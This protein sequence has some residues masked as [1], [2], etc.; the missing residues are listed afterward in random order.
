MILSTA[1]ALILQFCLLTDMDIAAGCPVSLKQARRTCGARKRHL[2]R[3]D[4]T[5]EKGGAHRRHIDVDVGGGGS[6]GGGVQRCILGAHSCLTDTAIH[7]PVYQ[8]PSGSAASVLQLS[9]M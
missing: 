8:R 3:R 4:R 5:V 7:H 1:F 9:I 2:R 6:G